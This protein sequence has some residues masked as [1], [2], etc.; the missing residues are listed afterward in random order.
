MRV[1]AIVLLIVLTT[2]AIGIS[3]QKIPSQKPKLVVGITI[4][5]MRYDYLSVY[6]DK[7]GDDG[8]K[9]MASTGA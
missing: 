2:G 5:G 4:S 7:L 6:W 3:G 1:R 8:L 9:K